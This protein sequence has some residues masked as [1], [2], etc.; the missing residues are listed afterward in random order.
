MPLPKLTI[1]IDAATAAKY[2]NDVLARFSF[3][4]ITQTDDPI[5][6]TNFTFSVYYVLGAIA[7]L[8]YALLDPTC[9]EVTTYLVNAP[10]SR[11]TDMLAAFT[12]QTADYD[13]VAGT[14]Y[15]ATFNSRTCLQEGGKQTVDVKK[16]HPVSKCAQIVESAFTCK[17][18]DFNETLGTGRRDTFLDQ[19]TCPADGTGTVEVKKDHPVSKCAQIKETAAFTCKTA[20]FN[21]TLGTGRMDTFTQLT[22]PADGTFTFEVKK[23]HPVSK[24][25]QIKEKAAFTCETADFNEALGTGHRQ[26]FTQLT[27]PADGAGTGPEFRAH[28]P[29]K[30]KTFTESTFTCQTA[31]YNNATATG[32]RDSFTPANCP[33]D[34]TAA[35]S[36]TYAASL[37]RE[38]DEV[39]FTCRDNAGA[40][41]LSFYRI[42]YSGGYSIDSR[43]KR[44]A[45]PGAIAGFVD[46]ID[47]WIDR[48]FGD[49]RHQGTLRLSQGSTSGS[50][51][52]TDSERTNLLGSSDE[53]YAYWK[54][55]VD[56]DV[57]LKY[58][59]IDFQTPTGSEE[60]HLHAPGYM[61]YFESDMGYYDELKSQDPTEI[62]YF[63]HKVST[64]IPAAQARMFIM[65]ERDKNSVFVRA[66]VF[67]IWY[68]IKKGTTLSSP[69]SVNFATGTGYVYEFPNNL[70]KVADYS[71]G[72]CVAT[73]NV[74][75]A[76]CAGTAD[77]P[78]VFDTCAGTVDETFAYDTCA[79][80]VDETVTYD[81]CA[82]TVKQEV[83][84]DLCD[85]FVNICPST[86]TSV[87]FSQAMAYAGA[88]MSALAFVYNFL[89]Q[90]E[91]AKR[92]D[93]VEKKT[94]FIDGDDDAPA[95]DAEAA[96]TDDVVATLKGV[97][98]EDSRMFKAANGSRV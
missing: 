2:K 22:C 77:V 82:G 97:A 4:S 25:A 44:S 33:E 74:T 32:R 78:I 11:C 19:L 42:Q 12:C 26:S 6:K 30:C 48:G 8:L 96:G 85:G 7:A 14:G 21:E 9:I 93:A 91:L 13:S 58:V 62:K 35:T 49:S 61:F 29:S 46:E 73:R 45:C 75:Y 87:R 59:R 79:G 1:G 68:L 20:D 17:T 71:G 89:G 95:G 5:P 92:V 66:R 52:M 34:G 76:T 23:D 54:V 37:C 47:G 18:A 81:T 50:V 63:D 41:P 55:T 64:F 27:C 10:I 3:F 84:Y 65:H 83:F 70:P 88:W 51:T 24:C 38:F 40:N 43:Y 31:D 98:S 16:D 57:D 80:T 15:A 36:G 39:D 72:T 94:G 60:L 69:F 28:P 90:R 56:D 67:T 53:I 86:P